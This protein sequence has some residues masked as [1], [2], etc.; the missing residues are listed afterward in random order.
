MSEIPFFYRYMRFSNP[1]QPDWADLF[2]A[3]KVSGWLDALARRSTL[4]AK[5]IESYIRAIQHGMRFARR[6]E[7]VPHSIYDKE[8][9]VCNN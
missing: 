7:K 1:R 6:T 9:E 8:T 2:C 4:T 5:T 3:S